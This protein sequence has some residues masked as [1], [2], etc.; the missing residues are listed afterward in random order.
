[1]TFND[2]VS[3]TSDNRLNTNAI[4]RAGNIGRRSHFNTSTR[5]VSL[6]KMAENLPGVH[7]MYLFLGKV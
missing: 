4:T 6:S 3:S 5:S 7:T 2:N 1:M